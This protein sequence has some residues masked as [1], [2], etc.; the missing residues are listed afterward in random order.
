MTNNTEQRENRLKYESFK[1][2]EEG[3]SAVSYDQEG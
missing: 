1:K 2:F 3:I